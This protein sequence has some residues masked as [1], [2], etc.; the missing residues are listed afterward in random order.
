M[1]CK[2]AGQVDGAAH[3]KGSPD[4]YSSVYVRE[5]FDEMSSTY[6]LM[7]SLTSFGFWHIWRYQCLNRAGISFGNRVYDL[8]SGMGENWRGICRRLGGRVGGGGAGAATGE[9][10]HEQ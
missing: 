8:M 2:Q 4:V 7:N 10:C 6:G 9:E 5:L 1:Y 3:L